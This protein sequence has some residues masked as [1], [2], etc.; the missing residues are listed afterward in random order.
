MEK[1]LHLNGNN[2]ISI[3]KRRIYDY[4]QR[5]HVKES[6][7]P[8]FAVFDDISPITTTAQNFDY[9]LRPRKQNSLFLIP[10]RIHFL[11]PHQQNLLLSQ[12]FIARLWA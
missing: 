5:K 4:F 6:G 9:L 8:L 10:A 3:V 11:R 1:K 7:E 12:P 2:P